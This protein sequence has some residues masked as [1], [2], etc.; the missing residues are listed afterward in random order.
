MKMLRRG[1][2]LLV[3]AANS[4]QSPFLLAVRLLWGWQFAESGWGHLTHMEKTIEFFTSLNI[5]LPA[6]NAWF[7]SI[8]EFVGGGLLILGLG[9]RLI[10][11]LLAGDMV[12]AYITADRDAL[13]TLFSSDPSNFLA[14]SEFSLLLAALIVLI[15][16]PG[17]L[18]LDQLLERRFNRGAAASSSAGR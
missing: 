5:P 14:A 15:F 12:V 4:M 6:A 1:Y 16:G 17:K 13:K 10:S 9:S 2:A 8:L 18:A 3:T 11:L 7:I